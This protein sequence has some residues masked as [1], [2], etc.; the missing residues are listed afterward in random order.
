[1]KTV[2]FNVK[3]LEK[4]Y[5]ISIAKKHKCK[6]VGTVLNTD[7]V[8]TKHITPNQLVYALKEFNLLDRFRQRIIHLLKQLNSTVLFYVIEPANGGLIDFAW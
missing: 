6:F 3:L 2:S 4:Y 7:A 5:K 8:V 1:M